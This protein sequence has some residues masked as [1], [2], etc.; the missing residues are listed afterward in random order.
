M[1]IFVIVK[2]FPTNAKYFKDRFAELTED[3]SPFQINSLQYR[4]ERTIGVIEDID[5]NRIV[6]GMGPVTEEQEPDVPLVKSITS[7]LVWTGVAYRWGLIGF[8]LFILLYIYSFIKSFKVFMNNTGLMSN[9]AF[10]LMIV[11]ISQVLEG[12]TS[13][14]FLSGH[15]YAT[16]LWYFALVAVL[17]DKATQMSNQSK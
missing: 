6:F 8:L 4:F 1:S 3:R 15:G 16:G 14:T 7:D 10:M 17:D 12:I 5:I 11:I 13:W 9:L 2:I